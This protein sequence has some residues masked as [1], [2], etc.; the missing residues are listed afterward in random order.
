MSKKEEVA[1]VKETYQKW[2]DTV[3]ILKENAET[4]FMPLVAEALGLAIN[5]AK[6]Y[7]KGYIQAIKNKK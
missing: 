1:K 2:Y 5:M 4:G 7:E 3:N 6:V